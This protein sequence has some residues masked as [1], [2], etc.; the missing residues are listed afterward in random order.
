MRIWKARD[1]DGNIIPNAYIIGADYLGTSYTN[2]DYQDNVYYVSNVR[3]ETGPAY[4]S[5][6]A[7]AAPAPATESD[8]AFGTVAVGASKSVTIPLQ[9][10]GKSYANGSDP[11]ITI[12]RVE[13][14][15]QY[16][17]D[18]SMFTV[19]SGPSTSA[20]APQA[21]TNVTVRFAPS[22][23][24][25]KHAALLVY[26]NSG[27]PLR[28]PLY[29]TADDASFTTTLV[30]RI[31]GGSDVSMT[32]AGQEWESDKNYRQ[33]NVKL[34]KQ[35]IPGPI[36]ATDE[37]VLYQTYLSSNANL[38]EMRMAVPVANG[39]Y[40]VR[41]HLVE[42]Y[43]SG[44]GQRVFSITAE[45]ELKQ[46]NLDLYREIG[47]RTAY[48]K[49]FVVTV[50]DGVLSLK[51][52]PTIDRLALAGVEIFQAT[53]K[54]AAAVAVNS[55]A[56]LA[57]R[58]ETST[59]RMQLYPNPVKRGEVV[60]VGLSGFQSRETMEIRVQDLLGRVVQQQ[61]AETNEQGAVQV[62]I[63]V[64]G[65]QTG[66]YILEARGSRQRLQGKLVLE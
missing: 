5:E 50:S 58:T 39:T 43:W 57:P 33:G 44:V 3:P 62:S 52:N 56:E 63:P 23:R 40:Q 9:N 10:Q 64:P 49:D 1:A 28:I 41:L 13:V 66:V 7:I 14:V 34:D 16:L 51:F 37:D 11:S 8:V 47:Y 20:L 27:K 18:V 4:Y 46:N 29:G 59:A 24:G 42:N 12:K 21:S 45:N 30:K 15:G 53:P 26:Y 60:Q 17:S 55:L 65:N 54:A 38:D 2:Y 31:K 61:R 19:T 25:I 35:I 22:S 32:I 6:L 36:A 48:V